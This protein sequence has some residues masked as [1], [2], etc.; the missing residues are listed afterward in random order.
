MKNLKLMMFLVLAAFVV[1]YAAGPGMGRGGETAAECGRHHHV[2]DFR[3]CH[4]GH[5]LLGRATN[6][7]PATSTLSGGGITGFQNGFSHRR[8]T[9]CP[10]EIF[11]SISGPCTRPVSMA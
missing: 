11:P 8:E 4:P 3:R 6:R 2:F 7:S 1:A 10:G 9:T 5:Y